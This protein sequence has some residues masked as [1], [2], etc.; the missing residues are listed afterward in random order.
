[1]EEVVDLKAQLIF[2]KTDAEHRLRIMEAEK[3]SLTA[4]LESSALALKSAQ[5][6]LENSKQ[7]VATLRAQLKEEKEGSAR[8]IAALEAKLANESQFSATQLK[9]LT[10]EREVL[11]T[12]VNKMSNDLTA[13]QKQVGEL[14]SDIIA[15]EGELDE[16][17]RTASQLDN[18]LCVASFELAIATTRMEALESEMEA[19]H[20]RLS[21]TAPSKEV[22]QIQKAL[23]LSKDAYTKL[24]QLVVTMKKQSE[25]SRQR[26]T[27]TRMSSRFENTPLP[28]PSS[29][30]ESGSGNY[31]DI[32][33]LKLALQE[34]KEK[35]AKLEGMLDILKQGSSK[36]DNN[37]VFDL[38]SEQTALMARLERA[39]N[40]LKESKS[41]VHFPHLHPPLLPLLLY[42]YNRRLRSVL[43][44]RSHAR[45]SATTSPLR[46]KAL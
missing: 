4:R 12:R 3:T 40:E 22:A 25:D 28:A 17:R 23:D 21:G 15:V 10:A 41:A 39:T 2:A 43:S 29:T 32:V 30:N 31:A 5:G 1:M 20:T 18:D 36:G 26:G 45:T 34:S 14:R 8:T 11:M 35:N 7:D 46:I 37:R 6:D 42:E 9:D 27:L 33:S 13:T 24:E 38:V 44:G 16:S 19:L